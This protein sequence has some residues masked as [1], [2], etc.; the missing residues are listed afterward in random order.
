MRDFIKKYWSFISTLK[1][2]SFFYGLIL[3][4]RSSVVF[5]K[6][7]INDPWVGNQEEGKKIIG[8]NLTVDKYNSLSIEEVFELIE[9]PYLFPVRCVEYV[10]GLSWIRHLQLIGGAVSRKYARQAISK[11]M[12]CSSKSRS[13]YWLQLSWRSDIVAERLITLMFLFPFYASGS[14]DKFQKRVLSFI[15]KQYSHLLNLYKG[16]SDTYTKI[17]VVKAIFFFIC[18]SKTINSS[19]ANK[20]L[21]IFCNTVKEYIGE[22]GMC[23]SLNP[24]EQFNIFRSIIEVRFMARSSNIETDISLFGKK[25][26]DMAACVRFLRLGDGHLSCYSGRKNFNSR[27]FVATPNNIDMALS[28]VDIKNKKVTPNF[29]LSKITTKNSII[30]INTKFYSGKTRF[31]PNNEPGIGIFELEV[32]FGIEKLINKGDIAVRYGS[33]FLRFSKLDDLFFEKTIK[34]GDITLSG[35]LNHVR[36]NLKMAVRRDVVV[37]NDTGD[38]EA[39]DFFFSTSPCLF[40]VR[41]FFTEGSVLEQKNGSQVIINK[42]KTSWVFSVAESEFKKKLLTVNAKNNLGSAIYV[43]LNYAPCKKEGIVNWNITKTT[44]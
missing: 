42:G 5:P 22:G 33:D 32:S 27:L 34:D 21:S 24:T 31:Y 23:K 7:F 17:L 15:T 14:D 6:R 40:L 43:I 44:D 9:K 39:S 38:L 26:S 29:G 13:K 16:I 41:F 35:G 10:T 28:L 36:P 18:C 37:H 8:G 3:D 20:I 1:Q 25:L 4:D 30:F 11:M 2:A 19:Q 12:D